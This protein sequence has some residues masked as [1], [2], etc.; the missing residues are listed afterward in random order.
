MGSVSG[1]FFLKTYL[2]GC[3]GLGCSTQ[4]LSCVMWYLIVACGLS[5][6]T[7][8][9][10]APWPGIEPT[11]PA[12]QGRFLSTGSSGKSIFLDVLFN[13]KSDLS[14][15]KHYI[16]FW[17]QKRQKSFHLCLKYPGFLSSIYLVSVYFKIFR[18]TQRLYFN[19]YKYTWVNAYVACI[20]LKA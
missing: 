6:F 20:Q 1:L 2:F 18:H 17:Y 11:S 4:D 9:D 8:W 12:T 7:T 14:L 19:V 13:S 10:I 3:V 5:C 16:K 15:Y